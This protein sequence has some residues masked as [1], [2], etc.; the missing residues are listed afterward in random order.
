MGDTTVVQ[1]PDGTLRIS[2]TCQY[3]GGDVAWD[4]VAFT[5]EGRLL[6]GHCL[7]PGQRHSFALK[8]RDRVVDP[9]GQRF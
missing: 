6:V 3:C 5:D 8:P 4:H 7:C 9:R 2:G 1:L